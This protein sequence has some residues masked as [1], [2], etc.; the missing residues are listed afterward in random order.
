[1]KKDTV[2]EWTPQCQIVFEELKKL[3]TS[4]PIL[5]FPDFSKGF[6]LAT[7]ASGVGLGVVLSQVQ[8]DS[9]IWPIAY[10]SRTLQKHESNYGVTDLEAFGVVWAVKH[11][12]SYLYGH[13]SL[14]NT[15]QPS[16][17]LARWGWLY[18]NWIYTYTTGLVK[19]ILMQMLYPVV[20]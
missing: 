15:P 6:L 4:S 2:Y 8:D 18:K 16:G 19:P 14:L 1:M 20:S 5:G 9:S 7:D 13:T 12:R 11:F 17:R 10:A 3:L